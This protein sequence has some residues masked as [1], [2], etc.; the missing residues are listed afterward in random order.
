M[1]C[2][3]RLQPDPLGDLTTE[4]E[5]ELGKLV[6]KKHHTDFYALYR[7][8]LAVRPIHPIFLHT[9]LDSPCLPLDIHALNA[10]FSQRRPFTDIAMS[11]DTKHL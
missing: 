5:R 3:L 9:L 8:P 11:T 10:R 6:R 7:Y 1:T 4:L 2:R